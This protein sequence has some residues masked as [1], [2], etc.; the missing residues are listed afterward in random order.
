MNEKLLALKKKLTDNKTIVIAAT[1]G[2]TA[3]GITAFAMHKHYDNKI[4]LEVTQDGLRRLHAGYVGVFTIK[5]VDLILM[6]DPNLTN[7]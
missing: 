2:V 5:G 7:N 4:L 6:R 3:A 1:A